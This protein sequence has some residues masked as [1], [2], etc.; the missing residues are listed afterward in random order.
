MI[1]RILLSFAFLLL[2]SPAAGAALLPD[3]RLAAELLTQAPDSPTMPRKP[4]GNVY[5]KAGRWFARA[6][7]GPKLRPSI[8]LP[9]C[10]T[11]AEALAR[12]PLL[13]EL[14]AKLRTAGHEER[15]RAILE[16]A[17]AS[18][19]KALAGVVRIVD[20]LC[21]GDLA[22]VRREV[23]NATTIKAIGDRWTSGDLAREHPDHVRP[24]KSADDDAERL[25]LHI[26][27][28]VGDVPIGDFTIDD[29]EAVMRASP[30]GRAK[31]TRRHV[32][33]LLHRLLGIA[34][35]PLRL[36][37]SNP[38]PKGFLPNV[39]PAKAKAW[40]YPDED[41][42]L[43]ASPAVSLA[44]RVVYGFLAR[45]APRSGEA[46]A[47]D[48]V[49][50]DLER[51][52]VNLDNN[53]TDDPRT[54]ALSPG[55]SSALR[56]WIVARETA[57]GEHLPPT[58]PLFVDTEGARVDVES[59]SMARMFRGHLRV[60]GVNRAELFTSTA[61]RLQIRLHDLRATM[62]TIALAM[63]R[64]ETW[65]ADRTGHK[66]S[67]MINRYRRAA[68][69]AAEL[70]LGDLTPLDVAIPELRASSSDS[71]SSGTG[72]NGDAA[73]RRVVMTIPT[74]PRPASSTGRPGGKGEA[75]R[76]KA[77][78]ATSGGSGQSPKSRV[79]SSSTEGG[80]RTHKPLR[81]ADFES[82]WVG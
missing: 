30:E 9:S 8:A 75:K 23:V 58:A 3:A 51:G 31:A 80:T 13:S 60:A 6:S 53:K 18:E 78:R 82:A 7:L 34:V 48:L 26:Y 21:K 14:A 56:A 41:R 37:A 59:H 49:D 44:W 35:F 61:T 52:T 69:T 62:I 54:W 43:L 76:R 4:T 32:A 77:M 24:K 73:P 55:V 45:E 19:G 16:R 29:A 47:L 20:A 81:T 50:V 5:D 46:G 68:R 72:G 66:S 57:S 79:I 39:G 33:Q 11:E 64:S 63:G 15:A 1:R 42:K 67:T 22:P 40:I 10:T 12:L 2:A 25:A 36:R 74:R 71:P 70:G 28:V 38:L 65:V 27:P 17:A